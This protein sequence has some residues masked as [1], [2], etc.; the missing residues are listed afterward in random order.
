[1]EANIEMYIELT[2]I[3][4]FQKSNIEVGLLESACCWMDEHE[5][6]P[7]YDMDCSDLGELLCEPPQPGHWTPCGWCKLINICSIFCLC[8]R[9]TTAC[10]SIMLFIIIPKSQMCSNYVICSSLQT[11]KSVNLCSL[12]SSRLAS[13]ETHKSLFIW[14]T[15]DM[16]GI[17]KEVYGYEH[18]KMVDFAI[19]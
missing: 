13:P 10:Y 15:S 16:D 4:V 14:Q 7:E 19:S 5:M 17:M 1:M 8:V 2:N 6:D 9:L 11:L 3:C 12:M 18:D